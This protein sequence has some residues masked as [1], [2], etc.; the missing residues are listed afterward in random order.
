MITLCRE[1]GFERITLRGD[2]DFTRT[3]HL[4]RWDQAGDVSFV[5]G[6]AAMPNLKELADNIPDEEYSFLERPPRYAIKTVPREKPERVKPKIVCGREGLRDI[7]FSTRGL[8]DIHFSRPNLSRASK[9]GE[10][11]CKIPM[12]RT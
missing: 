10:L 12:R 9:G 5:F 11:I 7:H 2:T 8:R 3:A 4:D 6:I 1:A